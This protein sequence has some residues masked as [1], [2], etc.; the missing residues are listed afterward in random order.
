MPSYGLTQQVCPECWNRL[1]LFVDAAN[2]EA[3]EKNFIPIYRALPTHSDD[4][5]LDR[6]APPM[7]RGT[8]FWYGET[9]WNPYE[10]KGG[11]TPWESPTQP[12]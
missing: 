8:I 9:G 10:Q 1:R 5:V 2:R 4:L 12:S 6:L 11:Y 7:L 3:R